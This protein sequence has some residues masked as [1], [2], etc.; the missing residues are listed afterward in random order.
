MFKTAKISRSTGSKPITSRR[1]QACRSA[2]FFKNLLCDAAVASC[3]R[4][5]I[6]DKTQKVEL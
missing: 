3:C 1:A 4:A 2:T 6:Y 5:L